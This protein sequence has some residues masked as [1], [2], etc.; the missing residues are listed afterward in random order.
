[1]RGLGKERH[2]ADRYRLDGIGAPVPLGTSTGRVAVK[3]RPV[4]RSADISQ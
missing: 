3:N 2:G 1:L 4:E